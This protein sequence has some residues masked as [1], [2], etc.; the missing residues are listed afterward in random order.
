ME[1]GKEQVPVGTTMRPVWLR[2]IRRRRRRGGVDGGGCGGDIDG[3]LVL[4]LRDIK[5]SNENH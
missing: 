2:Q 3:L 5:I 1:E 4:R